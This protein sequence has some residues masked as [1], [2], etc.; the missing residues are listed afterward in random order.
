MSRTATTRRP[1]ET[2]EPTPARRIPIVAVGAVGMAVLAIG[3]AAIFS[4]PAPSASSAVGPMGGAVVDQE[5]VRSETF[6]AGPIE[7]IG[8]T[9]EMGDVPLNV[10]VVPS[11]TLTNTGSEPVHLGDPHASVIQGCCPGPLQLGSRTLGPGESTELTFPLQM[12]AGMDGPHHFTVRVPVG[13]DE[14]LELQA[15]GDF[16]N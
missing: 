10:T 13:A 12:H 7:V 16:H 3:A 11:W 5:M 4:D 14:L 1:P 6:T 8:S 2:H 9:V 15:I